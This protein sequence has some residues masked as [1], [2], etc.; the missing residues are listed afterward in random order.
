MPGSDQNINYQIRP[1][2]SIERK[3]MCELVKEIQIIQGTSELRYIGMGA[4][5]FTDFLLFH[6][7]FGVTDM[8]SIEAERVDK[9]TSTRGASNHADRNI[10]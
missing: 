2:K 9:V 10:K 6:N 3:M 1:S 7:E 5:Y 4:K 8:I